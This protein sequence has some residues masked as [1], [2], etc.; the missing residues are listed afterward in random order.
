MSKFYFQDYRQPIRMGLIIVLASL[1]FLG[2]IFSGFLSGLSLKSYGLAH[3]EI[4]IG[5]NRRA[6][7]GE[8]VDGMTVLEAVQASA[9]AGNIAFKY[10]MD[11]NNELIV[12]S[13]DGYDY[14]GS[15]KPLNFYINDSK[16][17]PKKIHSTL[18]G[19]GDVIVIKL[20]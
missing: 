8:I 10:K 12:V 9:L 7:E 5:N 20:E 19:D 4:N 6:F 18:I 3:L 17:D 16:I 1:I 15:G 14:D 2:F 11:K 13:L